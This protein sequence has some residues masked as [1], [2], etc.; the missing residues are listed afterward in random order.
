MICSKFEFQLRSF[1]KSSHSSHNMYYEI[2]IP[3]LTR[4]SLQVVL[5]NLVN[6]NFAERNFFPKP[7]VAVT[8]ESVYQ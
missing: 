5:T 2:E 4:I 8:K 7:K 3:S 1:P 6:T